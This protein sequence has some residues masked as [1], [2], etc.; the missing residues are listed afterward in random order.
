MAHG[1][2]MS[3]GG[4]ALEAVLASQRLLERQNAA[5]RGELTLLRSTVSHGTPGPATQVNASPVSG[6]AGKRDLFDCLDRNGDGVVTRDEFVTAFDTSKRLVKWANDN[7]LPAAT[8]GDDTPV[9]GLA[10]D[11]H[12]LVQRANLS[13]SEASTLQQSIAVEAG[14]A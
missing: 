8:T 11:L 10:R 14:M 9:E 12:T 7:L 6:G 4:D 5:V 3:H 1:M 2:G 13:E